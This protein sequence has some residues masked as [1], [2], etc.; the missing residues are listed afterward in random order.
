MVN[1]FAVNYLEVSCTL[2]IYTYTVI[3]PIPCV[4]IHPWRNKNVL[5]E[6]WKP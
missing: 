1:Y 6:I 2:N 5:R 3:S 4:G